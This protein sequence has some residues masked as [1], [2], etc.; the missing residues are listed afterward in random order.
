MAHLSLTLLGQ[1][2]V[3]LDGQPITAFESD[4]G[5]ALLAYLA[6]E[7]VTHHRETLAALLWPD[8]GEQNARANLRQTLHHL[9][10][11]LHD[12]HPVTPP[13]KHPA[14]DRLPFLL[15]TRQTIH[16]NPAASYQVDL[17]HFTALLAACTQ[18][19]HADLRHCPACLA[20]LRQ[21]VDL[22]QGDFLAGFVMDDSDAFAEW[23]RLK[24]EQLHLQALDA[25]A[26][27][28]HA[29]EAAGQVALVRDY[30]QRQLALEPWRESAHRQLMRGLLHSG[31]RAAAL[32]QYEKCRLLLIKELGVDPAGET[33]A[34]YEQIRDDAGRVPT[35]PAARRSQQYDWG[36]M[37]AVAFLEGR[38]LDLAQLAAW[39]TPATGAPAARV[40]AVTGMGGVGKTTLAAAAVKASAPAFDVIIWRSLLNAP[41]LGE[42]LHTWLQILARQTLTQFPETLDEQLRLLLDYLRQQRCLL[43]LDNLES[44]LHAEAQAGEMRPG[45]EGYRLLLQHLGAAD[46]QSC[47]LLTS[48]EQPSVLTHLGR[49]SG[50]VRTLALAGLALAAGQQ[51]L[52]HSGLHASPQEAAWLVHGYSGNPLALQIVAH[53]IAELFGGDIAAFQREEGLIFDGIRTVL[54]Q[55]FAR[56]SPLER[57]LLIWLAIEREATPVA[58]LRHNLLHAVTTSE[59]LEAL[60][61][62]QQRSLL[63]KRSD[64]LTLQTVII[65]YITEQ[66]VT[67]ISGELAGD[68]AHGW[69][70]F[71]GA[72]L[73]PGPLA[74]F[75]RFALLKVQTKEYIHQSQVRLLLQPILQRLQARLGQRGLLDQLHRVLATLHHAGRQPGYAAGNLLNLLRQLGVDLTNY[76]FSR[77]CVW[78]ADLR[79]LRFAALNFTEADLGRS[80]FTLR[81]DTGAVHYRPSGEIMVAGIDGGN[82]CLW[83]MVDGQLI[84]TF[85]CL[86]HSAYPIVFSADGQWVAVSGQDHTIRIWSTTTGAQ[87]QELPGH[88]TPI[89]ALA[90]SADGRLL[91]S[92]TVEQRVWLWDIHTGRLLAQLDGHEHGVGALAFS[93]DGTRLASG[94]TDCTIRIWQ[95]APAARRGALLYTLQGHTR[96]IGSVAFSPDGALLASGDHEGVLRLWDMH[97]AG[98]SLQTLSGHTTLL[99]ALRFHPDGQSLASASADQTVRLWSVTGQPLYTLLGHLHEVTF[100]SFSPD[101]RTLVSSGADEKICFWDTRT[102]HA[103]QTLQTA[104]PHI[105]AVD[106]SPDGQLLASGATDGLIRLW[107]TQTGELIHAWPGHQLVVGALAF[108]P[109]GRHLVSGSHDKTLRIWDVANGQELHTLHGHGGVVH[110]VAWSPDGALIASGSADQT[111][112]LW[113]IAENLQWRAAHHQIRH[114][115]QA[116]ITRVTFSGDGRL[117]V[118]SSM[119]GTARLWAVANQALLYTLQGHTAGLSWAAIS[120]DG[121]AIATIGYDHTVRVWDA[122]TGESL[123]VQ[124]DPRTGDRVVAFSPDGE[125]LVYGCTDFAIARWRWRTD[126]VA[127][128]HQGHRSTIVALAF[129]RDG[130]LWASGDWDGALHLWQGQSGRSQRRLSAPGPYTGMRITGVTGISAAQKAA[131]LALGA[132]AA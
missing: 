83:Q 117:L 121:R 68:K 89:C 56:L 11:T 9:R 44:I 106:L 96:E 59:L 118:S 129:S 19:V 22:Y 92:G 71:A 15:V 76:D 125:W 122:T 37:P 120:P 24:Q 104:E 4:K 114:G 77:L 29:A 88:T 123:A 7:P 30:A 116:A 49:G 63:E 58:V 79:G 16:L 57:E 60:H 124:R 131:L 55:Q 110:S 91:A 18:H 31:E 70:D 65:E 99:R 90:F 39:I 46:H 33:V 93:P 75:N 42:L 119:D 27:L 109:D 3:T 105:A 97:A 6:S 98:R 111:I 40:V 25:L 2:Q 50:A 1:F 23:R 130:S 107:H 14:V 126:E 103:L 8:Y 112:R 67:Q 72:P 73:F 32:A 13:A 62:L 113:P 51:I 52:Q 69:A 101:G 10:K 66:L 127:G 41:P 128:S 38:T 5:R 95:V 17:H 35:T 87:V 85:R 86:N 21:A 108:S 48:R 94:G 100:L 102:G 82:F 45:Y 74:Y 20:R 12:Q 28:A 78:Q 54:D 84:D 115:H 53:T 34:L 81:F 64:G 61:A 26:Q 80:A 36:E 132:V 47:L 43:V